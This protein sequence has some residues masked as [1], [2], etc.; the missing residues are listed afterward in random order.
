MQPRELVEDAARSVVM[1]DRGLLRVHQRLQTRAPRFQLCGGVRGKVVTEER[2]KLVL[3]AVD[4]R[5]QLDQRRLCAP[6]SVIDVTYSLLGNAN[7]DR[8]LAG[9]ACALVARPLGL[10]DR[11]T[12]RFEG[13]GIVGGDRG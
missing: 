4:F 1:K 3:G 13:H 12:S 10:A 5:A 6:N 8:S 9:H 7:L 2:R 11:A